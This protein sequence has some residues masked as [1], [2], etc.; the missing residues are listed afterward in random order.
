MWGGVRRE[1][2]AT[3]AGEEDS[4]KKGMVVGRRPPA[5]VLTFPHLV[6]TQTSLSVAI[7]SA[8]TNN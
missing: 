8:L 3:L 5:E 2:D 7:S 4:Y 1:E 6:L